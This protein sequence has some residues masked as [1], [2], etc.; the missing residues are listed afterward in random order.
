MVDDKRDTESYSVW[1]VM[2]T[3]NDELTAKAMLT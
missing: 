3:N 1:R 2:N